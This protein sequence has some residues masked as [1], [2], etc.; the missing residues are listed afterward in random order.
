[1][2]TRRNVLLGAG[3]LALTATVTR[4]ALRDDIAILRQAYEQM[5]PGLYRYAT[6]AEMAARFDA[7]AAAWSRDQTQPQAYLALSHFLATVRCGHSYANFY[8][9]KDAV[10]A[11]L[12]ARPDKLPFHFRWLGERM[13]VTAH[14]GE[15]PR[16]TEVTAIDGRPVVEILRDLMQYARAD[17]GNDAKRVAQLEVQGSDGYEAFDVFYGLT[18]NK[19]GEP[20]AVTAVAP[21][22]TA[23]KTL[24]LNPIDLTARRAQS[25][26]PA[27]GKDAPKWT[28]EPGAVA[29]LTMP[30]WAMYNTKWDWTAFL[31]AAFED[32]ARRATRTLIVDLRGNEGGNDCG[33]EIISRCIDADLPRRSYERRVRYR[34]TP[35]NLDPYLD[36]WDPSF[37]NW[38]ND[39]QALGNGFYRLIEKDGE[40]RA[41]VKPKGPKFKGKL[42]VLVDATNSSATF[43][44]ADLVQSNRLGTLIGSP[45]GGNRRGINGGAFFFL[46]L[47][48]SGLEAD[49][50]LIGTFPATPQPDAGLVP[51]VAVTETP[52]DIAAGRD[53]V[54]ERALKISAA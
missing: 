10:A 4:A 50:P 49:L 14:G 48:N 23:P 30:D 9:Q 21:G 6:P 2:T 46:R 44:F 28:F 19:P 51:D 37:K 34:T 54:L 53:A 41:P 15:L 29:R 8:N 20:F 52:A 3:A 1:M 16:G 12:F 40:S 35:A 5:H 24:R 33:D 42:L 11:A 47:P 26:K 38:G 31:D 39:A 32:I 25:A 36:T 17:G 22:T 43:Q 27:K 13:I 18:R 7:L 45:T